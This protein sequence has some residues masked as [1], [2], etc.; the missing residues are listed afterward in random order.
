MKKTNFLSSNIILIYKNI[1]KSIYNVINIYLHVFTIRFP[2]V[3]FKLNF[4][5]FIIFKGWLTR[6]CNVN[7]KKKKAY[8]KACSREHRA[9]RADLKE[10]GDC[11]KH[12][13][14]MNEIN[15][16]TQKKVTD[17][18]SSSNENENTFCIYSCSLFH[19]N[20]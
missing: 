10:H 8:C 12:L 4:P 20:Y 9:Q 6:N 15:D 14:K 7:S 18:L 2:Y 13:A 17:N 3:L 11:P 16:A 5:I 19:K 1:Y